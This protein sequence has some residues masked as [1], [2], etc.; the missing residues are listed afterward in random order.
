M[1]RPEVRP[2]KRTFT[3]SIGMSFVL[4]PAGSFAMGSPTDEPGR[5]DD[6][7]QHL[8]TI[9]KPFYLQTTEVT[10]KQWT[11]VM[12]FEI[13]VFRGYGD[14]WPIQRVSW[15]NAQEFIQRL[16]QME[17]V[18]KY[19]LPWEAE[20]EYAC[21]AGSKGRFCFED[22]EEKLGEYA[23]YEVNSADKSHPAGEKTPNAFGLYDMHGNVWEWC[24]DWYGDYPTRQVMNPT[25]P[26]SRRETCVAGRFV[27]LRCDERTFGESVRGEAGLPP[28]RH[29]LS[30]CKGFLVT[31][32]T[33]M[34]LHRNVAGEAGHIT[35]KNGDMTEKS[36]PDSVTLTYELLIV[37]DPHPQK[38]SRMGAGSP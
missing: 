9:S 33:F 23:W 10:V 26:R 37:G 6:E 12:E 17:N 32:W 16:N 28:P 27:G 1:S 18:N 25:G 14:D 22:G 3:S 2:P 4:I 31:P 35:W 13:S 21:R 24:Q 34:P 29:G 38:V 8:V 36:A 5:K 30:G 20:W 19:R 15:D 7:R 11:V